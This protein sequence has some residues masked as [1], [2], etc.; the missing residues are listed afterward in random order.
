LRIL[1]ASLFVDQ[2]GSWSYFVVLSVYV[3]DRTH[4]PQW[5]AVLAIC[6]WGPGLLLAPGAA[7]CG[8]PRC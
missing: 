5:L 8:H 1:L 3:F 4:S 7:L 2:I 6:R